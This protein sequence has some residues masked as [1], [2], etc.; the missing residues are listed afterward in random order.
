[1]LE[2]HKDALGDNAGQAGP[3]VLLKLLSGDKASKRCM[4]NTTT[5]KRKRGTGRSKIRKEEENF[6]FATHSLCDGVC[7][8]V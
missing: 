6:G 3:K 1:M 8:C 7:V 2:N 5:P 4:F